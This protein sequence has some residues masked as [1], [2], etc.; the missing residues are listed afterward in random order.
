[1]KRRN[2]PT[3]YEMLSNLDY[4]ELREI[5]N[6]LSIRGRSRMTQAELQKNIRAVLRDERKVLEI[7]K[8]L[9]ENTIRILDI[10]RDYKG[11][12]NRKKVIQ[13]MGKSYNT[14][15]KYMEI[16]KEHGLVFYD[17]QEDMFSIPREILPILED[18][19]MEKE[20][21]MTFEDF[22]QYYLSVEDLKEICKKF[23]IPRSGNK[24]DLVKRIKK[25]QQPKEKILSLLPV[26]ELREIAEQMGLKKSGKKNE[27]IKRILEQIKVS[28]VREFKISS[29][30]IEKPQQ[31]A[32]KSKLDELWETIADTIDKEFTPS[33]PVKA[34][35]KEK[36]IE[37]SLYWFLKGKFS[38]HEIEY[39]K[40]KGRGRIDLSVDGKIGIELKY[41]PYDYDKLY[42]QVGRYLEDFRRIIVVL[43]ILGI[44]E[45]LIKKA[46]SAKAR[47]E[48]S[49]TKVIIKPI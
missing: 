25:L 19:I 33:R 39:E 9:P 7:L 3:L 36:Q 21:K 32:P 45:N 5:A 11:K 40:E 14:F 46:N 49:R 27:L 43:C 18:F 17:P 44:D 28:K 24:D 1:M 38:Q 12:V 37:R 41:N 13:E 30:R 2:L 10:V 31:K 26:D 22:L 4:E 48:N 47:I 16:G 23:E 8:T 20:E 6:S 35:L 42:G 34:R 29:K 15:R